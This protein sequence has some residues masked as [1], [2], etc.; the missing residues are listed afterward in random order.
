VLAFGTRRRWHLRTQLPVACGT[1]VGAVKSGA[2]GAA[3]ARGIRRDDRRRLTVFGA[4]SVSAPGSRRRAV[5]RHSRPAT[6]T[7][8]GLA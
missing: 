7:C 4:Y 2:V 1:D 8:R 5:I 6:P 3:P